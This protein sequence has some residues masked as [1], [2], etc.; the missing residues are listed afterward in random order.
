MLSNLRYRRIQ[1]TQAHTGASFANA[2]EFAWSVGSN[3]VLMWDDSYL[4]ISATIRYRDGAGAANIPAGLGLSKAPMHCLFSDGSM[5]IN[6][7]EVSRVSEYS[8]N[9]F[10]YQA[11]TSSGQKQLNNGSANPIFHERRWSTLSGLD[12]AAVKPRSRGAVGIVGAGDTTPLPTTQSFTLSAR[13]PLFL[14]KDELDGNCSYIIR[15][16][17]DPDWRRRIVRADNGLVAS[18]QPET[19]PDA[20]NT[21]YMDITEMTLN[22]RM[23]ETNSVPRSMTKTYEYSEFISST[24]AID[25]NGLSQRF[26]FTMPRSVSMI[27]F[28]IVANNSVDNESPTNF[29]TNDLKLLTSYEVRYAGTVHP[30]PK[31]TLNLLDSSPLRAENNEA[32]LS[33]IENTRDLSPNGSQ[34]S[35]VEWA[36]APIFAHTVVKPAGSEVPECS[37]QLDFSGAPTTGSILWFAALSPH[38]VDVMYNEAGVVSSVSKYEIV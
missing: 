38:A 5:R 19:A 4:S 34:Y 29:Y 25:A 30:S 7:V 33:F 20:L 23:Y 28:G 1:P 24:R 35:G 27:L 26:N 15:L 3:E 11:L 31:Y 14:T 9:G 6:N 32:F 22:L 10:A 18:Y 2:L 37:L 21:L 16:V 17:V 8:Q 36:S 13:L 12:L